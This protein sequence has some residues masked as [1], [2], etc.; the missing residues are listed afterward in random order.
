[1]RSGSGIMSCL[2]VGGRKPH[3]CRRC[4]PFAGGNGA[5]SLQSA[6]VGVM[7]GDGSRSEDMPSLDAF[8]E[9]VGGAAVTVMRSGQGRGARRLLPALVLA[10][11]IIGL[12]IWAWLSVN[13]RSG[14]EGQS[15]PSVL[16]IASREGSREQV[17]RLLRQVAALEQEIRDLTQAQQEA[18][19]GIAALR[20]AEQESR[21]PVPTYWYSDP[22]ALTVGAAGLP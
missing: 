7:S 17:D 18:S 8:D 19:Q 22:A 20:S 14:G 4:L 3:G 10:A 16:Q 9:E 2:A 21:Q 12:P 13:G 6:G 5:R 11:A 1:M 15:G